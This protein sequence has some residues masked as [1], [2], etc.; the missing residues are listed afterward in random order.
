MGK[1]LVMPKKLITRT[2]KQHKRTNNRRNDRPHKEETTNKHIKKSLTFKTDNG[3]NPKF[4]FHG[5][6]ED[7]AEKAR[8]HGLRGIVGWRRL[9]E[10]NDAIRLNLDKDIGSGL[11]FDTKGIWVT[12]KAGGALFYAISREESDKNPAIIVLDPDKLPRPFHK[13]RYG[14]YPDY[15]GNWNSCMEY[16]I[17]DIPKDAVVDIIYGD[18]YGISDSDLKRYDDS[19]VVA[20]K[21]P[22]REYIDAES[23]MQYVNEEYEDKMRRMGV[24]EEYW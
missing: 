12:D 23:E 5:T 20:K 19:W 21:E 9:A 15:D 24:P 1:K 11:P 16:V 14:D 18:K 3:E 6:T 7:V 10:Q 8:Q 17:D 4:I 22:E 13:G 2:S